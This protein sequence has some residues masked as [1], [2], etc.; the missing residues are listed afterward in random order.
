ML[1]GEKNTE[2]YHA[3]VFLQ[4]CCMYK[5]L[6]EMYANILEMQAI[7]FL[8][9]KVFNSVLVLLKC[10]KEHL[11]VSGKLLLD[12]CYLGGHRLETDPATDIFLCKY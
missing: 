6:V 9:T 10:N 7:L 3:F 1:P 12:I 8:A 2:I 4:D 5:P 11:C